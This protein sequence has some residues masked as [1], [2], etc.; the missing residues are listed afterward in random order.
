LITEKLP[1]SKQIAYACGMMGWSILSNIIGVLLIYFYLPPANVGLITLL[2]Q[3]TILSVVNL[4]SA[5][6]IGGRLIDAL[7]DPFIGQASDRTGHKKGRRIP[8]M[9]WSIVPACF[10]CML[11]FHPPDAGVTTANAVW[12]TASLILF[13]ISATTY[14]I[15]Y[16]ALMPEMAHTM[17]DK[18]RFSTFQQVG[19]VF[20]MIIASSTSNLANEVQILAPH[21]SRM[22]AFRTAISCLCG[23]G[24]IFMAIPAFTI[25]EKKYCK[26]EPSSVPLLPAI[27]QTLK[28]RNFLYYVCADFSYFMALY[29][30]ISGLQ[31]FVTVLCGLPESLGLELVGTMVGLSLLFYPLVNILARRFGKKI[32]V[33]LAFFILGTAFLCIYFLGKFPIPPKAQLFLLVSLAAFPLAALGILPP[34]ILA[35]LA[36]EDAERTGASKEG[37]FFAVKYFSVKLGQTFG[38]GLFAAL[39]LYGKD[40]GHDLGLRLNG[41]FGA[42]LCL[43]AALV[44]TRFKE[45]R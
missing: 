24:A 25:N 39:T 33:L 36:A 30:I 15:P 26:S 44:F 42:C 23:V 20:G 37:L 18:V 41:I 5:I 19:F 17:E 32:L 11:V 7:Y 13:F 38:I 28:N 21:F 12:L 22:E 3:I 10:F 16:N 29:I 9:R 14:I 35:D 4:P 2:S 8:Y 27:R 6:T 40:P 1:F 45:K 43:I 31:Y 34:A